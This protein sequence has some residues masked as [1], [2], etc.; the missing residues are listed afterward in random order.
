M[1][2]IPR[3]FTALIEELE[4]LPGVGPR[5]AYRLAFFLMNLDEASVKHFAETVVRARS[6]LRLCSQCFGFSEE[7]VCPICASESRD[8]STICVVEEPRDIFAIE[9]LGEYKGVY[10]VLGGTI[11]PIEGRG[12]SDIRIQELLDRVA[13]GIVREVILATNPTVSGEAT[14][15]YLARQLE[16]L[17]KHQVVVTRLASGIPFGSDLDFTDE[18]TLS[19]AFESRHKL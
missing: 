6:L 19:R 11:S 10:H 16:Q 15:L 9:K 8:H 17:G 2:Y 13:T 5:T 4:K 7:D 12:P 3:S 18:I 14:A 1:A